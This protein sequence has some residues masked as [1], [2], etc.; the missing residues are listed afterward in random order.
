MTPYELRFEIF[1]QAECLVE[2]QFS[3]EMEIAQRWNDNPDNTIKMDYP[4]FPS[5]E[6]IEKLANKIN[7]F[8][9]SK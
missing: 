7:E 4:K 2:T 5:F 1:R 8:V 3:S 6:E 9:S